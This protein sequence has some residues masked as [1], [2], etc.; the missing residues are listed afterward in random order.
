MV[1]NAYSVRLITLFLQCDYWPEETER[2]N[3]QKHWSPA[4]R[5]WE[6]ETVNAL[7]LARE[8][9]IKKQST[10]DGECVYACCLFSVPHVSP[11]TL[12]DSAPWEISYGAICVMCSAAVCLL[13]LSYP[14]T[15]TADGWKEKKNNN[16]KRRRTKRYWDQFRGNAVAGSQLCLLYGWYGG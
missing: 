6:R 13:T 14:V 15:P 9:K 16:T 10:E 2:A 4:E 8:H 1:Y 3:T 5:E 7:A 11:H 12:A